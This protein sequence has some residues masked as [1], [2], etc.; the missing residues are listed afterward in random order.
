VLNFRRVDV[1]PRLERQAKAWLTH[2]LRL[3]EASRYNVAGRFVDVVIDPSVETVYT[4]F[5]HGRQKFQVVLGKPFL[6][7]PPDYIQ[8][9]PAVHSLEVL[10]H[11]LDH[12]MQ[13]DVIATEDSF[14]AGQ[15]QYRAVVYTVLE[16]WKRA[17][18]LKM[19][20]PKWDEVRAKYPSDEEFV[21]SLELDDAYT[22]AADAI[23]N[24]NKPYIGDSNCYVTVSQ[25]WYA[26]Q[27]AAHQFVVEGHAAKQG[28]TQA[29]VHRYAEG[30][31]MEFARSINRPGALRIYA[32]TMFL[33]KPGATGSGRDGIF[34]TPHRTGQ[35]GGRSKEFYD[36]RLPRGYID[37]VI[38]DIHRR[39]HRAIDEAQYEIEEELD[40]EIKRRID[41]RGGFG[42]VAIFDK[43]PRCDRHRFK[44]RPYEMKAVDEMIDELIERVKSFL[45]KRGVMPEL[46]TKYP[47][48]EIKTPE[49]TILLPRVHERP[50][51]EIPPLVFALDRSGSM[52]DDDIEPISIGVMVRVAAWYKHRGGKVIG[53]TWADVAV[54]IPDEVIDMMSSL[55]GFVVGL[56]SP[57][58]GTE[59]LRSL[60]MIEAHMEEKG[61]L[62]D[63]LGIV[64][65]TDAEVGHYEAEDY[66]ALET[67]KD[68]RKPMWWVMPK[69]RAAFTAARSA[70]FPI[71][72][73]NDAAWFVS[74]E[75][76]VAKYGSE[77]GGRK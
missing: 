14:P 44:V 55:R 74:M 39:K 62:K 18:Q 51:R 72:R 63:I 13:G 16:V 41:P 64:I 68:P 37:Q 4:R 77:V 2:F 59:V 26:F 49:G 40:S 42:G 10:L 35:P 30:V 71:L 29:D 19:Y 73:P 47:G 67:Y 75:G 27:V 11:E 24:N 38:N 34:R 8:P 3:L 22:I 45:R 23:I 60:G 50:A 58:G 70:V 54:R 21:R 12:I 43:P 69:S 1:D 56:P 9:S 5:D 65:I 25:L 17:L 57:G 31:L 36:D 52:M 66:M 15:T 61:E 33:M 20:H 32:A 53:Y 76:Y 6:Y 48:R 7:A 28:V 46:E